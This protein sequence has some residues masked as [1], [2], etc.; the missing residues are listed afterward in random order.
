MDNV[1]KHNNFIF[2]KLMEFYLTSSVLYVISNTL[3][4]LSVLIDI[5][6]LLVKLPSCACFFFVSASDRVQLGE[7]YMFILYFMGHT[8]AIQTVTSFLV[9]FTAAPTRS[10][11]SRS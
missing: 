11:K 8:Q 3:T 7:L 4:F 5:K 10:D 2:E 1:Q 9:T 6:F